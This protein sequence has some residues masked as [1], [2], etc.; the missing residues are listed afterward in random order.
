M[1]PNTSW[2]LKIGRAKEH[3]VALE[4]ELRAWVG[5]NPMAIAKEKDPEGRRHTVFAEVVNPPPLNR[6]SLISGDCI[7]N[8]RSALDSL[9]YGIAIHETGLNPPADETALQFPIT[10]S[11]AKFKEQKSR[12]KSLSPAVQSDI[13]KVQPFNVPHPEHPPVLELLGLLNNFDKHRTINVMAAIPHNASIEMIHSDNVATSVTV[14]RTVVEGKTEILSFTMEPP[15]PNL[16]YTCAAMIVVCVAHPPGPSKSPFSELAGVLHS[17]IEE[18][19]KIVDGL[20][21]IVGEMHAA[22]QGTLSQ[23]AHFVLNKDGRLV[24][25]TGNI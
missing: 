14:Y 19:E 23:V 25:S 2:R 21:A 4:T 12:I 18:V 1:D 5:T 7:H 22:P 8:L 11:P 24:T 17:F 10:I 9:L 16:N 3:L 20:E 13:L 15:D 6:W